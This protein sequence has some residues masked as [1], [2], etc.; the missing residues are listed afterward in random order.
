MRPVALLVCVAGVMAAGCGAGARL[1]TEKAELRIKR[2]IER[3]NRGLDATVTCPDDVPREKDR[4]FT[5]RIVTRNG[6]QAEALVKQTDDSGRLRYVVLSPPW[7]ECSAQVDVVRG[8]PP[9]R[10]DIPRC[11]NQRK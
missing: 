3:N 8:V 2:G 4:E 11:S 9:R 7:R 6:D 10:T 5:C 1:D